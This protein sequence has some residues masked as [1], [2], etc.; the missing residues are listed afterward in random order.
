MR[1]F[2]ATA[3][4]ALA[5]ATP[6]RA[7][8]RHIVTGIVIDGASSDPVATA[9]VQVEDTRVAAVTDS[10]GRFVLERVPTGRR[11]LEI[12]RVGYVTL[13]E[14][15]IVEEDMTVSVTMTPKPIVLEGIHVTLERLAARRNAFPY[16]VTV[17]DESRIIGTNPLDAA[18]FVERRAGLMMIPCSS[19]EVACVLSRGG[20]ARLAVMIDDRS[21]F[22]GLY[23]LVGFPVSEIDQIEVARRC[24]MV[25][26]YTKRF[27]EQV[28]LG[29][30]RI[31]PVLD[32]GWT[33]PEDRVPTRWGLFS[34]IW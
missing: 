27:M 8:D 21:A 32:C 22:G 28:T 23:E 5:L 9:W 31:Y 11:S 2:L 19:G 33:P 13:R 15:M 16:G 26:V 34:N 12:S 6:A 20:R 14:T 25:R 18:D 3:L 17:Y 10:A 29:K 1:P 7:Q 24:P 30:R 4:I